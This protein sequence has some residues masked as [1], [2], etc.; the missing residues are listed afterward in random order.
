L[1]LRAKQSEVLPINRQPQIVAVRTDAGAAPMQVGGSSLSQ[2]RSELL[3]VG[4]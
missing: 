2:P 3:N 1:A 4:Q